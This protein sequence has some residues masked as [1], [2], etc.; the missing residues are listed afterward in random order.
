VIGFPLSPSRVKVVDG[1]SI[2]TCS[3]GNRACAP[4][5]LP[6][7]F[8]QA[9]QWQMDIRTGSP[10]QVTLSFPQLHDALRVAMARSV[11]SV[12]ALVPG[13]TE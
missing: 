7:R 5:T 9:L 2:A 3:R 1:P 10:T 11:D 4:K 8:W 6:V 12:F 13:L